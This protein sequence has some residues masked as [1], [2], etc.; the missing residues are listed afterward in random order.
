MNFIE[1]LEIIKTRENAKKNNY[2]SLIGMCVSTNYMDTLKYCLPMNYI[3]FE[4]IYI[5]TDKNDSDTIN[6]CKKFNNV[7]IYYYNFKKD[8][9]DFDKYG[10]LDY[11]QKEV[12]KNH[13]NSWY[14]I[15]DSDII[16]PNN[17]VNLIEK[18]N[19]KDDCIYGALRANINKSSELFDTKKIIENIGLEICNTFE[20]RILGCF[21]LYKKKVFHL[22][23]ESYNDCSWGDFR[24]CKNFKKVCN[25]KTIMIMHL[26]KSGEDN[27]KGKSIDF[28]EDVKIN[29][30]LEIL[31]FEFKSNLKNKTFL[32]KD[33]F[34]FNKQIVEYCMTNV[35]GNL[36]EEGLNKIKMSFF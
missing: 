25:T 4:K 32:M 34:T 11:I 2:I 21:Q 7:K 13:P 31:N 24:F 6:F 30:K 26:G 36:Q 1:N 5:V 14:L 15:F 23:F 19:L 28:E 20:D 16:L 8:N 10:G 22:E 35:I 9:K 18:I 17:F 27:W 3:H 33:D 12:Y 29:D